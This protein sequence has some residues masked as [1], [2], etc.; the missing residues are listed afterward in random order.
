MKPLAFPLYFNHVPKCAGTSLNELLSRSLHRS[1]LGVD[2]F[3]SALEL[4]TL[5]ASRLDR[6]RLVGSHFPHW[7]AMRRLAGWSTLTVLRR[8]WPRFQSLVRHLLRIQGSEPQALLPGQ[9]QFLALVR[10]QRHRDALRQ[11]LGWYPF[12]ASVA[13]CFL[14]APPDGG[15]DGL[16]PR[17]VAELGRYDAVLLSERLDDDWNALEAIFNGGSLGA[18]PRLNTSGEFGDAV[19]GPFPASLEPLFDTLFPFESEV[20]REAERLHA[21][22]A[23]RLAAQAA[24]GVPAVDRQASPASWTV[25]WDAPTRCAGFSDRVRAASFGYAGRFARR[26]QAPVGVLEIDVPPA[27]RARL[28]GVFWIAP[29]ECRFACRVLVNGTPVPM[30][31][32]ANEVGCPA[33]P[34]QLWAGAEVPAAALAGGRLEIAFERGD[35]AGLRE[36]WVLDLAVRPL[37]RAA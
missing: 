37:P 22:S 28:E 34:S 5:D 10:E 25:D 23:A 21:G 35:A 11:A 30:F 15:I 29:A 24:G 14:P 16:G 19:D 36:F 32:E 20:Y 26:V 1:A 2:P 9:V 17:A 27:A 31:D 7:A 13:Q 3:V 8:P 6:L 18:A 33:D 12:D 4:Y